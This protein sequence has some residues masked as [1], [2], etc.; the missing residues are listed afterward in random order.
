VY[1]ASN[2]SKKINNLGSNRFG[3]KKIF[4]SKSKK[5]YLAVNR[6]SKKE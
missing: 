6:L 3:R 4:G 2:Q 1:L 5:K